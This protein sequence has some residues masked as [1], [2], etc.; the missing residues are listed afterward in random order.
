MS[1]WIFQIFVAKDFVIRHAEMSEKQKLCDPPPPV[2]T[3]VSQGIRPAP[4]YPSI[5]DDG[6]KRTLWHLLQVERHTGA[7]LTETLAME[8]APSVCGL[9]I[10]HPQSFYYALGVIGKDQIKDFARRQGLD[11]EA[12][13][14]SCESVLGYEPGAVIV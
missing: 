6:M 2:F 4:G 11:Q 10:A 7:T 13:E 1:L 9:Y 14:L 12:V 8:P 5:P 3:P